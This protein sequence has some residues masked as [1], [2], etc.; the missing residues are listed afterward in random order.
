[1][2]QPNIFDSNIIGP[3][4]SRRLGISLGVNLLPKDGKVCSFDCLYCECGWNRDH[5]GGRFPES[6]AVMQQLEEKLA[7]MNRDG[8]SLDVI[9]FAGNG[10]PTLHP[11]FPSVIDRTIQLRDRYFPSAKVS[12]LSNATQIGNLRVHDAL[13][14]VDNNILKIDG[15][16]DA[17][18]R[19]IDQPNDSTYS[20]R[21]VVDG[22]KA[23]KGQLIVQT[24]FV[25]GEHDG[26]RVDNTTPA[27][28]A[29]WCDLMREIRP[30]QIMVYS[31][32]RP[33]PEPNLIRVA[34]DEM[35]DFVAPLVAEG[36]NVSIA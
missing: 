23:F 22:M 35:A 21:R 10:E 2:A 19:Q 5:R 24:M 25:R 20:V 11:D 17:T 36:F 6:D 31:L 30:H 12:V 26:Q 16:F 8:E 33:T 34:K 28:V 9:T 14:R 3:I 4:H 15:A 13:L 27:E 7:Q 29:A 18:I 32:D 1:M